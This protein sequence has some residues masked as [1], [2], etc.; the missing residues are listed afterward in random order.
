MFRKVVVYHFL[1]ILFMSL[2]FSLSSCHKCKYSEWSV[3]K[4][5]TCTID[6]VESRRCKCGEKE[7]RVILATGH[8]FDD[9]TVNKDATC[10]NE[11]TMIRSCK[12]GYFEE[13]NLETIAHNF[14]EW[15]IVEQSTCTKEGK[16]I[17]TCGCGYTEEKKIDKIEHTYGEWKVSV[18]STCT[19]DGMMLRFCECGT[20]E[21]KSIPASH[22]VG[23]KLS[24]D[25][26]YYIVT[27]KGCGHGVIE[28]EYEGIPVKVIGSYAFLWYGYNDITIPEGI[29]T[30]ENNAFSA[31]SNLK[32]VK[33]PST[34]QSIGESAFYNCTALNCVEI[35]SLETWLNI[36]FID[37]YSNPLIY[38]KSLVIN[39]DDVK[40]VIIPKE[41][42]NIK[43][44]TFY[45]LSNLTSIT[46]HNAV[47]SIGVDA[48]YNCNNIDDVKVTDIK[49]WVN[50]NFSNEYSNPL[51]YAKKLLLND[52]E[53]KELVI[54]DETTTINAYAFYNF[55]KFN[56]VTIP[57]SL[58]KV[59]SN[60]FYSC[61]NINS[62]KI[63]D[64]TVWT[65]MEFDDEYSNPLRYCSRLY[66]NDQLINELTIPEGVIEINAYAF[67]NC[68]LINSITIPNSCL[69]IGDY[70]FYNCNSVKKLFIPENVKSIGVSAFE[71]CDILEELTISEGVEKIDSYAFSYCPKI[72]FFTIPNSVNYIGEYALYR[73]SGLANLTLPFVG[74]KIDGNVNNKMAYLF[75]EYYNYTSLTSITITKGTIIAKEAF[76]GW[77]NIKNIYL[78][79]T[80]TT[81]KESAFA[82]CSSLTSIEIPDSVT[83]IETDIL[84]GCKN[85][86]RINIPFIG[87]TNGV[88]YDYFSYLFG[89]S[90]YYDSENLVPSTLK[91]VVIT[92][93]TVINDYAF[94]QC[95]KIQNITLPSTLTTIGEYAFYDCG[96][97][98][99]ITIPKNVDTIEKNAFTGCTILNTVIFED[100]NNWYV[101]KTYGSTS[102]IAMNVTNNSSNGSNLRY[103]Y[104]DYYWYKRK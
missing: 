3:E 20:T 81:I 26:T 95:R 54:P 49:S 83:N 57:K 100:T 10:S 9:W 8:V 31:S 4:G 55:N 92:G 29:T 40:E 99:R 85:L 73:C 43:N 7:E 75:S 84:R 60:A 30:I 52:V 71:S 51:N 86:I 13:R 46:I 72:K 24:D 23:L 90:K 102:G 87:S 16:E 1:M 80:I 48:F 41:I 56:S 27:G 94:Y 69:S 33:L 28:N 70:S 2:C 37:V 74:E 62:V 65:E 18:D 22:K 11:G 50:I 21:A 59:G 98:T 66:L 19:E 97:L 12:C 91:T 64:L 104:V 38:A 76:Y 34:I 6:G 32:N 96:N 58:T 61:Q 88:N 103:S 44:Y 89:G 14:S 25:G 15:S 39:G 79:D 35:N 78:P 17:R 47:V 67:Y 5:A 101:T 68:Y 36:D 42:T 93:G 63:S 82:Y 77:S 45:N 53:I